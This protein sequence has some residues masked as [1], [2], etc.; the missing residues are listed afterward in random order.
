MD[1]VQPAAIKGRYDR[2]VLPELNVD[3]PSFFPLDLGQFASWSGLCCCATQSCSA[4]PTQS[5]YERRD[6]NCFLFL[7]MNL[8]GLADVTLAL[9][10]DVTH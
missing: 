2:R 3:H 6:E 8:P 7:L 10:K 4:S 1:H 9:S 5:T